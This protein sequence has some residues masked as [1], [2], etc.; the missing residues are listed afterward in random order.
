[1][2][3]PGWFLATLAFVARLQG[4]VVVINPFNGITLITRTETMP[5]NEIMHIVQA[6]LAAPGLSFKVTSPGCTRETVRQTTLNFL[7]Q[8]QAQVAVN[9]HFFLPFPSSDLNAMLIGLGASN[10]NVYSAFENPVQNYAIVA[11]APAINIDP[12][13]HASI[14]HNDPSQPDG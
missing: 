10:G 7:N 1:K 9:G 13:N 11:K 12:T 5:R 4:G 3:A 6:D 14:V 2:F 8:E